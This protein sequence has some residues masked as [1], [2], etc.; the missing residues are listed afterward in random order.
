ML[1]GQGLGNSPSCAY[2]DED[3]D[4]KTAAPPPIIKKSS[5]PRPTKRYV[6]TWCVLWLAA[7]PR[8][9]YACVVAAVGAVA[10]TLDRSDSGKPLVEEAKEPP[11]CVRL[12]SYTHPHAWP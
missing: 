6:C 5:R 8:V 7:I 1:R 12:H 4:P 3:E 2:A 10:F 11:F 9:V